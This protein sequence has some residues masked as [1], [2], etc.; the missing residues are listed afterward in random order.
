M[1]ACAPCNQSWVNIHQGRS[2]HSRGRGISPPFTTQCN[3]E[4]RT[5][6]QFDHTKTHFSPYVFWHPILFIYLWGRSWWLAYLK[7]SYHVLLGNVALHKAVGMLVLEDLWVGEVVGVP[8]DGHNALIVAA[9]LSQRH[10][11]RLP[12]GHLWRMTGQVDSSWCFSVHYSDFVQRWGDKAGMA[13]NLFSRL[14]AGCAGHPDVPQA[15]RWS[16]LHGS[17]WVEVLAAVH[18]A[19]LQVFYNHLGHVLGQSLAVPPQLILRSCRRRETHTHFW[20]S[21]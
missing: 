13:A 19:A 1:F 9:Q 21:G 6:T 12:R 3:E 17:S 14:V 5:I 15:H 2:T 8:I 11:V 7:A 10:A 16:V 20:C 18:D 4:I